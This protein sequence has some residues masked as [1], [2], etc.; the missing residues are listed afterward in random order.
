MAERGIREVDPRPGTKPDDVPVV[1]SAEWLTSHPACVLADVRWSLAA[2]P[3]RDDFERGHLPDAL[4][5]DLDHDLADHSHRPATDGRHPLPT[6]EAFAETL[7]RLGVGATDVVVA[8]DATGGSTASRFVWMLRAIGQPAALLDGGLTSFN[9]PLETGMGRRPNACTV[10]VRPW[11]DAVRVTANDISTIVASGS[12][13]VLDA[14]S[15]DRYRGDNEPVDPRP[16]H[17]PGALNAPW[18]D[19]LDATGHLKSADELRSH[20]AG[21]G[22]NRDA[23]IVV[24]CG[25]GVTACSDAVA[26]AHAGFTDIRL[27]VPSWSGWCADPTR[28]AVTGAAPS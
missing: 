27:F 14:R 19:N 20:Y 17:I 12:G 11:P 3:Q 18:A 7:C 26:L 4:F 22:V 8:Y 24:S 13:I 6:A 28:A 9:G 2:G 16:G 15:A 10:P 1:V 23:P 5:I 25:S 21:L